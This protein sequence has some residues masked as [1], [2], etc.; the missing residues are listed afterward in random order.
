M[1]TGAAM[2]LGMRA[3]NR[4]RHSG[5]PAEHP[6]SIGWLGTTAL[7]MGGSNQSLF[8]LGALFA[9]QGSGAVPLLIVGLLLSWAAL[10]GWTELI[11]L[12]PN[13][14]GGIAGTCAEAFKPYS[15]VLANLTGVCYWWGWVPT[16]GLTA[17][18]SASAVHDWY[19]PGVPVKPLAIGI[20]LGFV[21]INLMGIRW[22]ARFAIPVAFASALLAF[23]SGVVP[24]FSGHVD[25]HQAASFHLA[26][27]FHGV[28][29]GITSAM[30]GLYLIG[31]AAPAFEAASCHVGETRDYK[32]NVPRAMYA[33]AG[34]ASIY[35]VLLP[36]VWLGVIG[37]LAD[38]D[39]LAG[40]LGPTFAPLLGSAAKAAAI[41]F[42]VFNMFH[43]TLQPLAG[44]SRTLSQL[45]E[46]GLL[47][48]VLA[49]RSRRDVPWVATWLTAL[50]AIGFLLLGDPTWLIAAANLTY[51]IGICLPSVAV[52]LLRRNAP[53]MERPYRAPRFTI[54]L[55]LVA[56]GA[57]GVS[58]VLG[59]QQFG[60]PT[61]LAGLGF[62][63]A[64]SVFYALRAWGDR[65]LAGRRTNFSSLHVKLTGAMLLVLVLD[66]A[67]YLVA[68]SNVPNHS[69]FQRAVLADIFVAVALL[70]VT[71]GLVLPGMLAHTAGEVARAADRLATGTVA[72]LRR[73]MRALADGDLDA[74][75][76][77]I[78]FQPVTVHTR[79]EISEMA[80]SFNAVQEE[81]GHTAGA[82]GEAREGLRAARDELQRWSHELEERVEERTKELRAARDELAALA[83]TDALTGLANHRALVA[84]IDS[85]LGRCDRYGRTCALLFLDVDH[86]KEL[87]DTHGHAAGDLALKAIAGIA[88]DQLRSIDVMGRWG[89]EEFVLLL[90]ETGEEEALATA[91]RVRR[92]IADH[93]L[94]IDGGRRVTCSIGA[95]VYPADAPDRSQL[96]IAADHAMYA[97]KRLGRNL[98]FPASAPAVAAM[99]AADEPGRSVSDATL[100]AAVEAL[101]GLVETRDAVTAA[102]AGEV[103]ALALRLAVELGLS[104][105]EL[106]LVSAGARLHDVGKVV[107]PD[108]I[109]R[110]P[111]PLDALEWEVVRTHPEVGA[112]I[113][114]RIPSLRPAADLIRSHHERWDGDGYPHRLVGDEIPLG[115]RILAVADAFGA[116][117]SDRPYRAGRSAAEAVDEIARH[118]GTQFDPLVVDAL[119]RLRAQLAAPAPAP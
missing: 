67:G 31:F 16:C 99:W 110:K 117:T 58:T 7:A 71:V 59:F 68:V 86:F 11:L 96:M 35:F 20:V 18:L 88:R 91:D 47:P 113:V 111:G 37:P 32:R 77:R 5:Y 23:L 101:A 75:Q 10:P 112:E 9:G 106:A 49:L 100:S 65:K 97:A 95:A 78:G 57:W 21:A 107:V 89:G 29:G 27:P 63:Y 19:L 115:A 83:T 56:A 15:A 66:G 53:E 26:T 98:C 40:S 116:V 119:V 118:R 73:A 45:S 13:R 92:A 52:W 12:W 108:S 46:D 8:L 22:V 81:L 87:N 54:G 93:V 48:R 94:P 38:Y 2:S 85:E 36:V 105:D 103:A 34:M 64:G 28:F 114:G 50:M 41:W 25:W 102:H 109:L 42:M 33:S 61:V 4:L 1:S 90:P 62:A 17:I 14:V 82:L 84:A 79:D 30:A 80:Q 55:G 76:A 70:T 3:R 24:V 104:G 43:G 74:A 44:A 39:N 51:L 69:L 72:D 60:L 6:R